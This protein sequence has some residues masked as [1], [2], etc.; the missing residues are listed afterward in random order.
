MRRKPKIGQTKRRL[1]LAE[2]FLCL[3]TVSQR[4]RLPKNLLR[5]KYP[6]A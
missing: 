6:N 4:G 5:W 3:L 1:P 2:E